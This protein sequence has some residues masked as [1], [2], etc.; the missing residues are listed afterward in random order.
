MSQ[1]LSSLHRTIR[2]T[3]LWRPAFRRQLDGLC[4]AFFRT[5]VRPPSWHRVQTFQESQTHGSKNQQK[6]AAY[7]GR[8]NIAPAHFGCIHYVFEPFVGMHPG[9]ERRPR[10]MWNYEIVH[11]LHDLANSSIDMVIPTRS[12]LIRVKKENRGLE[13]LCWT[14]NTRFI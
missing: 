6:P 8:A 9:M 10:T 7:P 3:P 14:I 12:F 2:P 5:A 1:P 4:V 11:N 13:Q